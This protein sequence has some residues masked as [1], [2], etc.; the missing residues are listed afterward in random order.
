MDSN[1]IDKGIRKVFELISFSNAYIDKEAPWV[2][3]KKDIKRMNTVLS[4][5]IDLIKRISVLTFPIMP[6]KSNQILNILNLDI[7]NLSFDNYAILPRKAYKINKPVPIFP[8]Y[9]S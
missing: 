5:L 6:L 9:E 1:E 3:K 2:L 8:R 4:I 7:D